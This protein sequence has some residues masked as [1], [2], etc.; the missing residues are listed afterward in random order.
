LAESRV[1]FRVDKVLRQKKAATRKRFS[2]FFAWLVFLFIAILSTILIS[3]VFFFKPYRFELGKIIG[4]TIRAPFPFEVEDQQAYDNKVVE[5]TKKAPKCYEYDSSVEEGIIDRIEKVRQLIRDSSSSEIQGPEI[6]FK[7]KRNFGLSL[8]DQ[9]TSAL[10]Q[11]GNDSMFYDN[12][13]LLTAS[14]MSRRGVIDNKYYFQ[15]FEKQGVLKILPG[16]DHPVSEFTGSR[17]VEYPE[18]INSVLN[19]SINRYFPGARRYYLETARD[20]AGRL[21]KPNIS[22]RQD[23][24]EIERKKI[25]DGISV[26]KRKFDKNDVIV[27]ATQQLTLFHESALRRLNQRMRAAFFIQLLANFFLVLMIFAFIAYFVQKFRPDLGFTPANIILISLPG[28]LVLGVDRLLIQ[29]IGKS[30]GYAFPAGLVGILAVVLLDARI[31]FLLV[32]WVAFMSGLMVD[33]NF[34]I[35]FLAFIG[36]V[37]SVSSLYVVRERKE[38]WGAGIRIAIVN[39]IAIMLLEYIYDPTGDLSLYISKTWWGLG[40]GI[41]CAALVFPALSFF[42]VAFGVVTDVRLLELTGIRQPLLMQLEEKA[43]GSYQHSLNVAK[44]AEPAA[45]A[46]GVNYI[47]VRAGAYYHDVGK[48]VKSK[49]YSENQV[50]A[51]DKKIYETITPHMSVLII[52]KHIK[53]GIELARKEKVPQQIIDFIPQHHG[54]S[55]IRYFYNLAQKRFEE[56][57]SNDSV[58]EA[59]FRYPGPKPQTIETAIVMLADTV[60][61]TVTSSL[62]KANVDEDDIRWVVHESVLRQFNDGQ[63]DECNMT[64]RDL[65]LIEDSFAKTLLGRY[66]Y[67]VN[68]PKRS[69]IQ[70]PD[71]RKPDTDGK[72]SKQGES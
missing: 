11:I 50:N 72:K 6:I 25:I 42:E 67:R 9:L 5:L 27:G 26:I 54:T 71:E 33:M 53:E 55:L 8:S 58:R 59:D 47:L 15:T 63:F 29:T 3:K 48:I 46:V 45:V 57:K 49:Y 51:E 10:L 4:K 14:I 43:P 68:Y 2:A 64:L 65:H 23:L 35:T 40:N 69:K 36:G 62:S 18:E 60:E 12:L 38:M 52:K 41:V 32:S 70:E 61:A 1:K 22:P 16:K 28:L 21:I 17:I 34:K 20:L 24:T 30:A 37:T 44:L 56:E 66:H 19:I 7:A 39:F 31:A 13:K